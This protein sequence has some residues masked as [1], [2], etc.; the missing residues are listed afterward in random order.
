MLASPCQTAI[1]LN[2]STNGLATRCG[3]RAVDSQRPV[4]VGATGSRTRTC[5]F[6]LIATEI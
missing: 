2:L 4:Q 3:A 5:P 6:L 1:P